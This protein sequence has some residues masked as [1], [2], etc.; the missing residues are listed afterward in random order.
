MS[1]ENYIEHVLSTLEAAI[2]P[3]RKICASIILKSLLRYAKKL[4][5]CNGKWVLC[6]LY[7]GL[8][9]LFVGLY[10]FSLRCQK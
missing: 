4:W 9:R 5:N 2:Y 7:Q 1:Y 10:R 6:P 8:E 3:L